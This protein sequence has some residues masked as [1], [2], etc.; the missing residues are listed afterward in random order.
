MLTGKEFVAKI[1]KENQ[2]LF[3]ASQ[4]NVK[5]YFDSKPAQEE[6]VQHFIG[7]MVNERMNMVEISQTIANLPADTDP[8]ELQLLT[9]QAHDEAVHFRMVKEVIEHIQ[10]KAVDVDAAI[11]AEAAKPTAKGAG[12]LE[13]YG[14]QDDTAALAAYQLV[15]EGR[16]EAVWNKMADCIEDPFISNRYAKIARDEGFHANIGARKLAQL[17]DSESEQQRIGTLVEKM[18]RD[19]YEISCK[20]TTAAE[21]GRKL[22]AEA[23]GW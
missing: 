2:A 10:G 1:K 7:R 19:L 12:L 3:N 11:A 17:M 15:A 4:I 13:K 8:V 18:R 9:Q 22:V 5:A 20:N 14:A 21:D 23:Y 6:L 16:A